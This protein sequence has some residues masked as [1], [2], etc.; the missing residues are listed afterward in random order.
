M[1]KEE[2]YYTAGVGKWHLGLGDAEKTDLHQAA[3]PGTDL[4]RL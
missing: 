3:N 1:L 2:G 4:A